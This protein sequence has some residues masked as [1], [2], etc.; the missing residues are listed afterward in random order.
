VVLS[1]GAS[2]L[3]FY[4]PFISFYVLV[5]YYDFYGIL[6]EDL[7][8]HFSLFT[9][10]EVERYDVLKQYT[11]ENLIALDWAQQTLSSNEPVI[12]PTRTSLNLN[13]PL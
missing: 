4:I 6:W 10:K 3:L 12:V 13:C 8:L 11:N 1:V 7:L 5:L 2:F 9:K